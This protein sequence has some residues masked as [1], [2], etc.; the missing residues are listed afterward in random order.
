MC[1]ES[2]S[3]LCGLAAAFLVVGL[4]MCPLCG[5]YCTGLYNRWNS[6][7]CGPAARPLLLMEATCSIAAR[8]TCQPTNFRWVL[9]PPLQAF[10]E[11]LGH[12]EQ[13][14]AIRFQPACSPIGAALQSC[15][16]HRCTCVRLLPRCNSHSSIAAFAPVVVSIEEMLRVSNFC[17]AV[18]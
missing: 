1:D 7:S 13:R 10:K 18:M 4:S 9:S 5:R 2:W 12:P 16:W 15:A 8:T 14:F 3:L 11:A 6:E 17:P